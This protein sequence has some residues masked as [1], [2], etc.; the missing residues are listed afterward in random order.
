MSE[1]IQVKCPSCGAI[2]STD[3]IHGT[4]SYCEYCKTY[5]VLDNHR[6]ILKCVF[7]KIQPFSTSINEYNKGL[8]P[9]LSQIGEGDIY[10]YLKLCSPVQR[11]YLPVREIRNGNKIQV[12]PLNSKYR[13]LDLS[14][15]SSGLINNTGAIQQRLF[16]D[17]KTTDY[18]P[19]YIKAK[20]ERVEFI[21]IDESIDKIDAL[22]NAN[23]DDMLIIKYLPLSVTQSNMGQ[24]IAIGDTNPVVINEYSIKEGLEICRNNVGENKRKRFA[25]MR[26]IIGLICIAGLIAAVYKIFTT[27]ITPGGVFSTVFSIIGILLFALWSVIWIGLYVIGA[28]LI[29]VPPIYFIWNMFK[30]KM[31]D[32]NLKKTPID[33]GY[34]IFEI[35]LHGRK[36][37][38]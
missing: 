18:N 25:P 11:F 28:F 14:A 29:F 21:P 23:K 16:Q 5:S 32:I 17:L 2:I 13:T 10:D 34:E 37:H 7:Y 8:V 20:K 6:S 19:L 9:A 27:G 35:K 38:I 33:K 3:N 30:F 12:I 24:I 4:I 26:S 31:P 15:I 36:Q 1:L 22:Y